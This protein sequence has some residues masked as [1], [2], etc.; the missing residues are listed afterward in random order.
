MN[1]K[2]LLET[3]KI[4]LSCK[5]KEDID[6]IVINTKMTDEEKDL[7]LKM[8]ELFLRCEDSSG[9]VDQVKKEVEELVEK[10]EKIKNQKSLTERFNRNDQLK[11]NSGNVVS[12][13]PL[14]SFLYTLMRDHVTPGTIEKVLRD[15]LYGPEV[16][17][18]SNGF[19]AKYA[20]DVAAMIKVGKLKFLSNALDAAFTDKG[21]P[22]TLLREGKIREEERRFAGR[23]E[24]ANMIFDQ[25]AEQINTAFE[26]LTEEEKV[27]A[28]E[29]WNK[30]AEVINVAFKEQEGAFLRGK[31]SVE[32]ANEAE[33]IKQEVAQMLEET[34]NPELSREN[35]LASSYIA[36]EKLK[37]NF[38][39][40]ADIVNILEN[41]ITAEFEEMEKQTR[42]DTLK[43]RVEEV[44]S[45]AHTESKQEREETVEYIKAEVELTDPIETQLPIS[46]EARKALN[47][48]TP[49]K[50]GRGTLSEI[51][52]KTNHKDLDY[53]E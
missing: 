49:P 3:K 8:R 27:V 53:G 47:I 16:V 29:A 36:L 1:E 5:S 35:V 37:D 22:A 40:V 34:N 32:L 46:E 44:K 9:D 11:E 17:T 2:E 25:A 23:E 51:K 4:L 33:Q 15:G 30:D 31:E 21:S 10:T 42:E 20:E 39:T 14:V 52:S 38:P 43:K 48:K 13:D 50:K 12:A 26:N 7:F 18:Y 28:E 6:R 41:E 19:L 24:R 45:I